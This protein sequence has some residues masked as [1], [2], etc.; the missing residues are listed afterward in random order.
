MRMS[1]DKTSIFSMSFSK[2]LGYFSKS[3]ALLNCVGFT[4]ML[5][6]VSLFS[7]LNFEAAKDVLRVKRPL[8]EQDR[9]IY[10]EY[11]MAVSTLVKQLDL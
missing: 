9:W 8:W 4:N 6:T 2:F 5:I 3:L 10:F 1:L 7:L 11:K